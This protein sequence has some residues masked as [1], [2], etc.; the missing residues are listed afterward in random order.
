MATVS[1]RY[2]VN[3]IDAAIGFYTRH[4]G[5]SVQMHPNTCSPC[6]PA[7][8]CAWCSAFPGRPRRRPGNSRRHD[9]PARR[10]EPVLDRNL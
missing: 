3:D 5:F 4:L 2:I 8:T 1:V 6:S 9:A 10:L 7:A